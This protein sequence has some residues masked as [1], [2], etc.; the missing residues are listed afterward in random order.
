MYDRQTVSELADELGL[1]TSEVLEECHRIGVEAAWAGAP[2]EPAAAGLL[3]QRLGRPG[4]GRPPLPDRSSRT[5]RPSGLPP[6]AV[7]SLPSVAEDLAAR[8]HEPGPLSHAE[9]VDRTET[10]VSRRSLAGA[11]RHL[12][13]GARSA[14]VAA[15]IGIVLLVAAPSSPHVIATAV[16]WVVAFVAGMFAFFGGN[17]S[18]YRITTHPE[19][20]HGLTVAIAAM[21]AGALLVAGVG[22]GAWVVV[23]SAP[24]SAAPDAIGG[25][26]DVGELRWAFHRVT[27]IAGD[28]WHRPAKDVGS[29]WMAAEPE[30]EPRDAERV[31]TTYRDRSCK[32]DH[33]VPRCFARQVR[34]LTPD[35]DAPYPG[36]D[37][38][39]AEGRARCEPVVE[40]LPSR[41]DG[42]TLDIEYPT[43]DGWADA[44]HDVACVARITRRGSLAD[45]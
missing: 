8:G 2:L 26:D 20:L 16:V 34:R 45:G 18:R 13:P 39:E 40:A 32:A 10:E 21:V 43:R 44:D 38:L 25:R 7:G 28:G 33:D 36:P 1:P 35:A 12:D 42:M 19:K 27:R 41:P 11:G 4:Q 15:V 9:E 31:E 29:C 22:F 30:E 24:A 23:R 3:R 6:T 14:I 5:A 37:A 17:R